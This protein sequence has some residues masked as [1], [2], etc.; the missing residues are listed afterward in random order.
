M[1]LGPYQAVFIA[2]GHYSLGWF[3]NTRTRSSSQYTNV[4]SLNLKSHLLGPL[5]VPAWVEKKPIWVS[6]YSKI[7]IC[8]QQASHGEKEVFLEREPKK[9]KKEIEK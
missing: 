7:A 2:S 6:N 1:S 4:L 9:R 8:S 3:F 5:Y